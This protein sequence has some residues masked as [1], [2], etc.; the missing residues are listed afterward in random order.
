MDTRSN[1]LLQLFKAAGYDLERNPPGIERL[2]ETQQQLEEYGPDPKKAVIAVL[3]AQR[4]EA[5]ATAHAKRAANASKE[6][7][8]IIESLLD[9]PPLLCR[10]EGLRSEN[11]SPAQALCQ[12]NGALRSLPIHPDVDFAELANLEPWHY[13]SV[14][15]Q[16]LVVVG[17]STEPEQFERAQGELV[18]F[19]AWHDRERGLVR[20]QR[21][22]HEESVVALSPT[23]RQGELV[24]RSKLVL[25]RGDERWAIAALPAA[26]V[27]SRFEVP[28][29]RITTRL[30]HLAGLDAIVER[31]MEDVLLCL[32]HADVRKQFDLR[33]LRGMLLYSFNPGMG[34]TALVR[35]LSVWLAELG[36]ELG[37]DLALYV[38][39][40]NEL[41]SSWH[42]GDA[43]LVREELCGSLAARR[44]APRTRPL[45]QVVVLDEVDSLGRR[46]G[47]D[48]GP[49]LSSAHDDAVQ[50]LLA[51]MDGMIQP[52][53]DDGRP[54]AHVLWIGLTNRPDALDEA[55]KRPGRLGDLM[56]EMPKVTAEVAESIV[57]IY[58]R[59]AD[60]PWYIGDKIVQ[61]L[62]SEELRERVL[63]PAVAEVFDEVV[64]RYWDDGGKPVPI[65]A[66]EVMA[67]VHY[68]EAMNTAKKRAARRSF[69]GTGV[70]AVRY[71]DVVEGLF[72]QAVGAAGQM[73]ADHRMLARQLRI[74]GRIARVETVPLDELFDHRYRTPAIV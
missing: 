4:G 67:S 40:P 52:E 70:P 11:G 35:G 43:R 34:K 28:I 14:H 41:K 72:E 16:E 74:R 54:P 38:V 10:L 59:R 61:G 32:V 23:L 29:D 42:G 55:L 47:G 27:E 50:S 46:S 64:L 68:M 57:A 6:L 44:D 30:E 19:R 36:D 53:E 33:P 37:F 7:E 62:S 24:P 49:A 66:G 12:V 25:L 15:P 3:R 17:T 9:A 69:D 18:E 31:V 5:R 56:L 58:A 63:R 21:A 73:E 71:E 2:V 39:K 48:T 13:V 51:E 26:S 20:V 65:K 45:Y 22:G 1:D 8:G 60:L